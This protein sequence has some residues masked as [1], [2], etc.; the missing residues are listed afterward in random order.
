MSGNGKLQ[1]F[2]APAN[3]PLIGQPYTF[4]NGTIAV[5]GQLTCNCR[6]PNEPMAVLMSAP[7]TCPH[8][9]KTYLVVAPIPAGA[10]VLILQV[11]DPNA[12]D[13]NAADKVPS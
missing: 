5:T 1:P 4:M 13:P 6:V 11:A 8:C 3:T 7:V 10:N 2:T 12:A 9:H